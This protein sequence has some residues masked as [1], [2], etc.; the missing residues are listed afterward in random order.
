L[1]RLEALR[2]RLPSLYRPETDD[3]DPE[4]RPLVPADVV[5]VLGEQPV[6]FVVR[7]R[8]D[9]ALIVRLD[10]PPPGPVRA[11]ALAPGA[12]PGPGWA[13]ELHRVRQDGSMVPKPAL[14]A[15][16]RASTVT[17][18]GLF[19]ERRFGLLLRRRS[20][21]TLALVGTADAL[22]RLSLD[23]ALVLQA[24]WSQF[25]DRALFDPFFLRGRELHE[26]PLPTPGPDDPAVLD[27]PHI[28]D[29]GRLASLVSLP[30]WQSGATGNGTGPG[31]SV[32]AYRQR[33]R[34]IVTLYADGLGTAD[35]LRRMTEAQLP[36]DLDAPPEKRDR[37]FAI[38]E[39]APLHSV[40][41]AVQ[42]PG[43]PVDLVGPLMHW[44][45]T[46][47]GVAAVAP[48]LY[49]QAPTEDERKAASNG[50]GP[51]E[52]A[53]SPVVERFDPQGRELSVG[54]AYD[55]TI[56]AGKTLRLRPAYASWLGLADGILVARSDSAAGEPDPTAPGPWSGAE[57][58][59]AQEVTALLRTS[60][61]ALWAAAVADDGTGSLWRH[62]GTKW[63]K[64]VDSPGA[65]HCLAEDGSD[66]LIGGDQGLLRLGRFPEDG[67]P[68]VADPVSSVGEVAVRALLR[69]ADGTRWVGTAT[70]LGRLGDG[71][72]FEPF[73]LQAGETETEVRALADDAGGA[74]LAGTGRGLFQLQP[75]AGAVYWYSGESA[76]DDDPEWHELEAGRFPAEEQV[77][78]PAVTC[79]RR[80][81]DGTLWLGTVAGLARYLAR[82]KREPLAFR[83]QLE[84][85]PDVVPGT[86]HALV[87][88][89]RGLLWICTDRGLFRFDGR[90]LFQYRESAETWEQLGR[91]D[92]VYGEPQPRAR[93]AWRF[94]REDAAW[95]RFGA[96]LPVPDW[97]AF[98]DEPRSAEE[99][100]VRA[101]AFT[102][103]VE[104]DLLDAW[105][106]ADF[107]AAGST[108]VDPALLQVR[109]KL[110]GYERIVAGGIPA[111]PRLPA[112][113]SSWRYLSLEPAEVV[114]PSPLPAWTIEGRLLR[115]GTAP[116]DAEPDPGRWDERAPEDAGEFDEA[117]FAFPPAARVGLE[118]QP[119]RPLAMLARLARS[120]PQD[121]IDPAV[122]DRVFQGL[123]QV[124][125]AGARAA[126]AV[127]GA[128]VR[129]ET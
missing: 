29:L 25:A 62:D 103:G 30:P 91:A 44:R 58:A 14:V 97:V 76:S 28:L 73:V 121:Q 67:D 64:A 38:E 123:Q 119:R 54:I 118:W 35:A 111:V 122:L 61:Q 82:S 88:D 75:A 42:T 57:D 71:D 27:F 74:V 78:L 92:T 128:I 126:L 24:H 99:P 55:D 129:K 11:I 102:D 87:E 66:L 23:A 86:V 1:G 104:A 84:A 19:E 43:E 70:G 4:P 95:Q 15:D 109:C 93:G 9:G 36:V 52:A 49:V 106:P 79:A 51:V 22:D 16:V 60:E 5:E 17:L 89:E 120:S 26:P 53:R 80:T 77:F 18:P 100:E 69:A 110:P 46:N 98:D 20:L 3:V 115:N 34:R 85:F 12:V 105:N 63:A 117:V 6:P 96:E 65:L 112:G 48:T 33:I 13:L 90:D 83:T 113:E 125:P 47:D 108:S 81:R 56:P 39:N 124:R 37:P 2:E 41:L 107:A 45:V 50:S 68:F 8:G 7:A 94:V 72:T 32:E 116:P 114:E 21:L 59:P 127:D 31:E 101:L 10:G 40:Q